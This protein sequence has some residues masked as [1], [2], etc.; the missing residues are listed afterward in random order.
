M[1]PPYNEGEV[2]QISQEQGE[3]NVAMAVC[4]QLAGRAIIRVVSRCEEAQD[5]CNL[6]LNSKDLVLTVCNTKIHDINDYENKD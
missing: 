3:R 4:V 2:Q 6:G 5:N 1:R